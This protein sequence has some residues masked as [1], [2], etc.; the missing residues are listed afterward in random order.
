M[1]QEDVVGCKCDEYPECTHVLYFYMG[2]RHA[3]AALATPSVASPQPF[4]N[5]EIEA[6]LRPRFGVSSQT[7]PLDV[8]WLVD[9]L[10]KL[11]QIKLVDAQE[12]AAPVGEPGRTPLGVEDAKSI[13]II[14]KGQHFPP[15]A[16]LQSWEDLAAR[17]NAYFVAAPTAQGAPTQSHL[18]IESVSPLDGDD[19]DLLPLK[20]ATCGKPISAISSSVRC[21]ECRLAAQG[22]PGTREAGRPTGLAGIKAGLAEAEAEERLAQPGA[23]TKEG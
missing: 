14:V 2:V 20:C 8:A 9:Q 6:L 12:A 4:N 15:G 13:Y 16:D 11:A 23:P 18:D 5:W 19:E 21:S 10:N 3:Q 1:S 22:A 17:L 7:G